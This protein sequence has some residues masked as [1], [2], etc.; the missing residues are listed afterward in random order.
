MLEVKRR[1]VIKNGQIILIKTVAMLNGQKYV[2]Q[3]KIDVKMKLNFQA[4]EIW[5]ISVCLLTYR[6]TYWQFLLRP[7]PPLLF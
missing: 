2:N 5:F 4:D 1:E 3:K 7:L 6:F